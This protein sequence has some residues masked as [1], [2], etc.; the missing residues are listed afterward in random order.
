MYQGQ[1][2]K[3]FVD[4]KRGFNYLS[5]WVSICEHNEEIHS[6]QIKFSLID[7]IQ[8]NRA[9]GTIKS[10]DDPKSRN[11]KVKHLGEQKSQSQTNA[12]NTKKR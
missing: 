1:Q 3:V 5:K 9:N 4:V 8:K 10:N 2:N 12:P 11:P 6:I 7:C